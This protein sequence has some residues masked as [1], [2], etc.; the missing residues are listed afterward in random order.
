M[1][2]WGAEVAARHIRFVF[3]AEPVERLA[4]LGER[5]AASRLT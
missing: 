1:T 5:V 2:G 4:E 3:S